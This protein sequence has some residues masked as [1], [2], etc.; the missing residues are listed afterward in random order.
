MR[1][2]PCVGFDVTSQTFTVNAKVLGEGRELVAGAPMKRS[3]RTV[4]R[5]TPVSGAGTDSPSQ[6]T[7]RECDVLRGVA[8][9]QSNAQI[10]RALH[11]RE[12]TVKNH[13]SVLLQ[14]L[15]VKN[16][17]QLAVLVGRKWPALLEGV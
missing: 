16:R 4:T 3:S 9:G 6:L 5:C 1:R 12:Q 8:R 17:V 2:S 15:H 10:A 13:V 14:K 7:E 11:I